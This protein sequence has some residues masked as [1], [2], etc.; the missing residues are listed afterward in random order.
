VRTVTWSPWL[1]RAWR[2]APDAVAESPAPTARFASSERMR[3]RAFAERSHRGFTV[4]S[5]GL[6][7]IESQPDP[8]RQVL[9]RL[10]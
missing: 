2:T 4:G 5:Y 9:Q 1:A 7:R 3:N 8:L 10:N 6:V